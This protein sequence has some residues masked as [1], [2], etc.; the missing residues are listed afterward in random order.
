MIKTTPLSTDGLL[1]GISRGRAL[2]DP[3]NSKRFKNELSTWNK[4]L[5]RTGFRDIE[6]RRG[7]LKSPDRRTIAFDNREKILHFFRTLDWL[8]V[9]YP[10]MPRFE[11]RVMELYSHGLFTKQIVRK[12]KASDKHVRN[13]I[14]RYKY[15]V[16]SIIRMMDSTDN[17][18]SLRLISQSV[19]E[20]TANA[21][22]RTE[23]KAA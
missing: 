6:D 20:V 12:V 10:E 22:D 7:N 8:M 11:R 14:K 19:S 17:P 21:E 23:N 13:V 4:K 3:F 15:L 18:P 2:T 9:C 5:E 16:L 1:A